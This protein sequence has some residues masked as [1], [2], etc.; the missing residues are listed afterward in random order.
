M[1]H[2]FNSSPSTWMHIDLNSCF[3]TIEQQ[4]NPF[5]RGK[6]IAVAAYTSEKSCILAPSIEAKRYGVKTGMRVREGKQLCP[7]LIILPSDP[8]KYRFVNKQLTKLL[9]AY[10]PHISVRSIDE[11]ILNFSGLPI[12]AQKNMKV[13]SQEIKRRIKE[14]IGEHLTVSV[15]ISTNPYLAKLAAN[16]HKPDGLDEINAQNILNILS[17]FKLVDLPY[18]KDQNAYRLNQV[19]IYTPVNFYFASLAKL[20]QAFQ[21]IN[22][23]YWYRRLHGFSIDEEEWSRKTIGHSYHLVKFTANIHE[24]EKLLCKLVEKLGR[25]LRKNELTAQGIHLTCLFSDYTSWNKHHTFPYKMYANSDLFIAARQLLISAPRKTI[26][27][28]A[29]T[30]FELEKNLYSQ[31]SFFKDELK[32]R[33]LVKALDTI[34]DQ[35]GEFSIIPATMMR[36]DDIILDRIAFGK[37]N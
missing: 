11:M 29:V 30:S 34:N 6:P 3:A 31:L 5:L 26:R 2:Q 20:K 13:I 15:G 25:R 16:I 7:E 32:K 27:I 9:T 18:I 24:I 36:M 10:S 8:G 1:Q 4:A 37:S 12:L 23:Y 28:L 35:W 22:G 17:N 33:Q 21:S 14:E 19:G